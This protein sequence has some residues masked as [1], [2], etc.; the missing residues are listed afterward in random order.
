MSA[1]D[2]YPEPRAGAERLFYIQHSNNHNTYV[3]EANFSSPEKLDSAEPVKIHIVAYTKG[4]IKQPLSH[5]QRK[6]AYGIDFTKGADNCF[7]F[8]LVSY[9][10]KSLTLK[11]N[12][13]GKPYVT[14]NVNGK[15]IILKRMFLFNNKT[16]TKVFSIN[17]YGKDLVTGKEVVEKMNID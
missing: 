12:A 13:E 10:E 11:L 16:G 17:F 7:K 6:L 3:Y 5:M 4:G 2:G 1:Q 14:V 8:N 9:P 15:T